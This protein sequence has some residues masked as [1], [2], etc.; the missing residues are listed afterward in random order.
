M[1]VLCTKR[2]DS[3]YTGGKTAEY[4]SLALQL[5]LQAPDNGPWKENEDDFKHQV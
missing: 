1:L 2:P 3:Q 4:H 5:N